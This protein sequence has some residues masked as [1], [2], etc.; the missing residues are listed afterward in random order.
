MLLLIPTQCCSHSADAIECNSFESI[1]NVLSFTARLARAIMAACSSRHTPTLYSST[2]VT[3][4]ATTPAMTLAPQITMMMTMTAT[5][6]AAVTA[7]VSA[8][9]AATVDLTR[10]SCAVVAAVMTAGAPQQR[11]TTFL[12]RQLARLLLVLLLAY[13]CNT[14]IRR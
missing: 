14:P 2:L 4:Q 11:Y 3:Q 5:T 10:C 1:L 13:S 6:L 9:G 7:G 8:R 12:M